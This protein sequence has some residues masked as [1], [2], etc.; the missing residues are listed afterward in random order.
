MH[1]DAVGAFSIVIAN[2]VFWTLIFLGKSFTPLARAYFGWALFI[3]LWSF[4]YGITLGGFFSYE[5]TLVWNKY[6]QAMATLIGPFFFRFSANV[7]QCYGQMRK[8]FKFYLIFGI[9]NA[10][11]LFFTPY[12]VKGLWS[13]G[14]YQYQPL[15]GPLYFIFTSFF[16]WCTLHSYWIVATRYKQSR[17]IQ[18]THITLFLIATGLAYFGGITLFFQ[19]F[20]IP[21]PT[22][23]V[24]LI[25]AYVLIIGYSIYKYKFM[26]IE[27]LIKKTVV[28]AGLSSLVVG[29]FCIPLFLIPRVLVGE[30]SDQLQFW[31]LILA[32]MAVAAFI[33]P[34][35]QILVNITDKY[36]FQKKFDLT[37]IIAEGSEELAKI[38]SLKR[39]S[40]R[41]VAYLVRK[42]R[43][44]FAVVYVYDE[45]KKCFESKSLHGNLKRENLVK[46]LKSHQAIIQYLK[47]ERAAFEISQQR[48]K[49]LGKESKQNLEE[50]ISFLNSI[51]AEVIIPS[52]LPTRSKEGRKDVQELKSILVLGGKMSDE[53]YSESELNVFYSLAQE[54]AT[55]ID[56]SRLYDEVV[57]RSN[58]LEKANNQ[59]RSQR[60]ELVEKEK[61]ATM[62]GMA[63]AMGHEISNPMTSILMGLDLLSRLF[64]KKT[65]KV[66]E[67]SFEY[68]AELSGNKNS[69]RLNSLRSDKEGLESSFKKQDSHIRF[70]CKRIETYVKNMKGL[71][72]DIGSG[73]SAIRAVELC[74]H[75]VSV[76]KKKIIDCD[77]K[78][79]LNPDIKFF[80]NLESL[81]DVMKNLIMNA[82][83]AMGNQ[84]D[85]QI[86]ISCG[87][88]D[89]EK[90]MIYI[91][92][93][94]NGPGISEDV[95][96]NIWTQ[97]FST[98]ER[99]DDS[100]GA[101]GQGQGLYMC[102]KTV[103]MFHGG[104]INV[105]SK[106]GEG[107]AFR[108]KF[109][110]L[111]E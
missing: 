3:T 17:G 43:I 22:T 23:G 48:P 79:D 52:F 12:Y 8:V 80:G 96:N 84:K 6:C 56:N 19:G 53:S 18:R 77:L 106:V 14:T 35:N 62:V 28:F 65:S 100:L 85:K 67:D 38:R 25:L 102:K 37:R 75:G 57:Q 91:E 10:I 81:V 88:D 73:M 111:H 51:K 5:T 58:D 1:I 76:C 110:Q 4:G 44:K 64:L 61:K 68:I 11:A 103:E 98:K 9:I 72:D 31:L 60:D 89:F 27:V 108:I 2:L 97:G 49:N 87:V 45:E 15:G 33:G 74:K 66:F 54:S 47:T 69:E 39:L 59:I 78:M 86:R 93:R 7:A 95:L 70:N 50:V 21:L 109:N 40:R 83:E 20:K 92:V 90:D 32:G 71:M 29:C 36:L 41:I 34:A 24:Y 42:C 13:F 46:D 63:G 104:D 101:S 26:D 30:I 82:Y 99:K 94:D 107:T 16:M 105:N 55:A